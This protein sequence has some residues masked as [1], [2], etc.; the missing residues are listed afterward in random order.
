[1]AKQNK[2]KEK[3]KDQQYIQEMIENEEKLQKQREKE[4]KG[5][6]DRIQ[7]KMSKMADTVVKNEREKQLKEE[8]RLLAMQNEKERRDAEEERSRKMRLMNQNLEV[9]E[10]LKEQME[11]KQRLKLEEKQHDKQLYDKVLCQNRQDIDK[12]YKKQLE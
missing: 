1:M 4:F 7:A 10:H 12:E 5:R 3:L 8:R 11:I 6:L 2:V 9:Q